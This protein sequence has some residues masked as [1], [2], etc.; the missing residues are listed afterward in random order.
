ML[1][2]NG[3]CLLNNNGLGVRAA[4]EYVLLILVLA[5]N[6]SNFTE[7]HTLTLAL[8]ALLVTRALERHNF[9]KFCWQNQSM[10][11]LRTNPKNCLEHSPVRALSCSKLTLNLKA[12][13]GDI[14]GKGH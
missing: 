9:K 2:N 8:Y 3:L 4:A 6:S 10:S 7:I 1:S 5:V 13:L 11:D 12:G 14:K